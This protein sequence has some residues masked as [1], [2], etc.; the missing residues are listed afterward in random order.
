MTGIGDAVRVRFVHPAEYTEHHFF[1]AL[2]TN[3]VMLQAASEEWRPGTI[4]SISRDGIGVAFADHSRM[5]LPRH[6][7]EWRIA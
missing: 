2:T 3:P 6:S 7:A 5:E 1:G 4:C